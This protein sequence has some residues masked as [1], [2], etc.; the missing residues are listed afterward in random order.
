MITAP[1]NSSAIDKR[2]ETI[3]SDIGKRIRRRSTATRLGVGAVLAG[4]CAIGGA[5]VANASFPTTVHM[6]G[7][8]KTKYVEAFVQC[9]E[10]ANVET[11][12]LTGMTAQ[13]VLE[14]WTAMDISEY[15]AVESRMDS[16]DQG[17]LGRALSKCQ[18][19]LGEKFGEP[20]T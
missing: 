5:G 14:G 3:R 18:Q 8:V 15:T 4:A 17:V 9:S 10:E 1:P 7:V 20:I 11:V 2:V 19:E 6:Q 12:I 16:R 13:R